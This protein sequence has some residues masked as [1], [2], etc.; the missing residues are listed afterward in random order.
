M[1]GVTFIPGI[2]YTHYMGHANFL[3]CAR[4][5]DVAFAANSLEETLVRFQSARER[6]ALVVIN[7]PFEEV[8]KLSYDINQLPFDCL[9]VWN[10]PMRES[11]IKAL[12]LW[13]SMLCAGRKMPITGGSDYH[14]DTPFIFLGGPTTCVYSRSGSTDDILDALRRGH[15]YITF[16]TNG[17]SLK[18][19][20]GDGML[21]DSVPWA[22]V[23]EMNISVDGL[24]AGDVVK[25]ITAASGD[26]LLQAPADGSFE[27]VYSMPQP[28]FAR[29]EVYRAFLPGLPMLPALVSNPVY[30]DA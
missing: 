22:D 6:G 9:E 23:K 10:G 17:P 24:L 2:E 27:A 12:G 5:Y 30:F 20:A 14:R 25:V 29:V 18:L 21:G 11:N 28:G 4:P 8:A 13:H 1:D 7:H 26:V 15:A 16:A 3:G 19:T